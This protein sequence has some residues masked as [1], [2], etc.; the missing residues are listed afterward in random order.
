MKNVKTKAHV[1]TLI[2]ETYIVEGI[3]TFTSFYFKPRLRTI[4]NYITRNDVGGHLHSSMNLSI[5]SH[6]R[7]PL[8]NNTVSR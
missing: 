2:C 1:A 8:S 4:I 7:R 6:L 3:S 5:F